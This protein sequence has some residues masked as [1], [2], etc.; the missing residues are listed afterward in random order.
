MENT[1]YIRKGFGD[2]INT[3]TDKVRSGEFWEATWEDITIRRPGSW[4]K[5][6]FLSLVQD[7]FGYGREI[8]V[9][10]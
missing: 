4:T 6:R 7:N 10:A 3:A 1:I 2:Y 9:A 8:E 5:K